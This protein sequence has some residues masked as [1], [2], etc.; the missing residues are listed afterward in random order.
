MPHLKTASTNGRLLNSHE[1]CCKINY[2][3]VRRL[4]QFGLNL[5]WYEMAKIAYS[6]WKIAMKNNGEPASFEVLEFALKIKTNNNMFV[7][8]STCGS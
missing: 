5:H 1:V 8:G 7:L 4:S 6:D 2:F 3:R